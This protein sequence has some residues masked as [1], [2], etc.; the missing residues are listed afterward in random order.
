MKRQKI[1]VAIV[2]ASLE[3]TGISSI[4]MN[5]ASYLDKAKYD[6][7]IIA[8]DK[9]NKS[10]EKKCKENKVK[11]I[12]LPN[13]RKETWHY[14][15]SLYRSLVNSNYD[16]CHANGSSSTLGID[17][18][19]AKIAGI[20][21]RIAHSHNTTTENIKMHKLLTPLFTRTY[22]DALAC[23]N[24]AG[25]WLFNKKKF[26][27]I[28][29]GFNINKFK[30]DKK[31]RKLM[32]AKLGIQNGIEVIGH[33]GRFNF[34]KNHNFILKIFESYL[35]INPNS[36]LLLIG[37]GPDFDKVK[38]KIENS[39][40]KN[41]IILYGETNNANQMYMAMDKFIFPSRFEGLPVTLLEAQ[42]TG[43]PAVISSVITDEVVLSNNVQFET[44][45]SSP[46]KWAR[47]LWTLPKIDRDEFFNSHLL[48]FKPYE[49][50]SSVQKLSRVYDEAYKRVKK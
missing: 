37:N 16:I 30:F 27:V 35:K 31:I 47:D 9:I 10:Y 25:E 38:V 49:I 20:K 44:L 15:R 2:T 11:L 23:G 1:K 43:L 45:E 22:T 50:T 24:K 34:Q 41:K 26:T 40:L 46:E 17:L 6:L 29:N 21:V 19:I 13:K 14:Y 28:P 7:T 5:Y 3:M 39:K 18:L 48:K 4:I 42:I 36:I 12:R 8:G 33:I 32:R